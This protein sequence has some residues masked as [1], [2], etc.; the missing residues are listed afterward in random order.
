MN[1]WASWLVLGFLAGPWLSGKSCASCLH[2]WFWA[3]WLE[4]VS[5]LAVAV[6]VAVA[7]AG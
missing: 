5:W 1:L 3:L 4:L 6:A 7:V 2:L